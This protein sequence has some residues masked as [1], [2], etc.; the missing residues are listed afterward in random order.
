MDEGGNVLSPPDNLSND[1]VMDEQDPS[2]LN[3]QISSEN[4]DV[5]NNLELFFVYVFY[6]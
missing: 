3:G 6:I 1:E 2:S 4:S 5:K